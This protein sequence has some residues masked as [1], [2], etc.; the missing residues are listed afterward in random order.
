MRPAE[1]PSWILQ[2]IS[3]H[4]QNHLKDQE[5]NNGSGELAIP[6]G[7][8]N[9]EL[10]SFAG[11]MRRKGMVLE[12]IDHALQMINENRCCPPLSAKEVRKISAG[13]SRYKPSPF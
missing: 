13:I 9:V 7:Q 11:A 12:E 10:T 5:R 1:V 8:R 4:H 6:T 2:I 3:D